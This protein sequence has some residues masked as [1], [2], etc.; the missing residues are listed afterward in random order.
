MHDNR[1]LY[2]KRLSLYPLFGIIWN[3]PQFYY[4]YSIGDSPFLFNLHT[5][6]IILSD[7]NTI[8]FLFSYKK[9]WLLYSPIFLL[10]IPSFIFLYRKQRTFYWATFTFFVLYIYVMSSWECWWYAASYGSRVM[11]DI[12]PVFILIIAIWLSQR[13]SQIKIVLASIFVGLA[14]ML[15]VIQMIQ[16]DRG[17]L[18]PERMTKEHYWYIFGKTEMPNYTWEYLEL[19]RDDPNWIDFFE[20]YPADTYKV[21][22]Y[23]LF[24]LEST[25]E[26]KNGEYLTIGSFKPMHGIKTD[27]SLMEIEIT[28]RTSDSASSVRLQAETCSIYNCYDWQS[29][30]VSRGL[31][32]NENYT[33]TFR[34]NLKPIR[35]YN[36]YIQLYLVYDNDIEVEVIECKVKGYNLI[37]K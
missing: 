28:T 33:Q 22:E 35:H 27:E 29:V 5:E 23:D 25:P 21:E 12:Y 20:K 4:W 36:D 18:H 3:I 16:F 10:L 30:E 32:Q 31:P 15:N 19:D 6:E 8:D 26:E 14:T 13:K 1:A 17:Y 11:I 34:F 2:W 7:P 24:E 9:G 37:R